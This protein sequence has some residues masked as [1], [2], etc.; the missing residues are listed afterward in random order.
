MKFMFA[1]WWFLLALLLLPA[2]AFLRGKRGA[3]PAFVYSSVTLLANVSKASRSRAGALLHALR[4]LALALLI[5]ALARP[6]KT[7]TE[8]SVR[9]SG[10]D[11]VIA[12]DLS[13][14]MESEDFQIK[15]Q[16]VN[17]LVVAKDTIKQ[18]ILKRPNDRIGLVAF[19]GRAYIA[20][21]LTL[22]HDF[23]QNNLDRLELHTI[24]DGTAIGSGLSAAVNRL[25]DVKSKSKIVVLMTDGQN[26]AGK[27]PPLTAAEAAKALDVKVYTI[28]VGIRGKAPFP[29]N[30]PFGKRYVMMDVDI[31][32]PTLTSIA[33]KTGGK[34]Y[35]ADST[36]TLRKVYDE[37]DRFEKTEA[38]LKK[39]VRR[40]ELFHWAAVPGLLLLLIEVLLASTIW[41]RL[42]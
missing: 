33:D 15:G 24:E 25:R 14:S 16:R 27:I 42:P 2:L 13:G 11:I 28:G 20:A 4:W 7:Q 21:P 26:N 9:A 32:E 10:V 31:D 3:R 29:Q 1:N 5:V 34:Y 35:R 6:Q 40:D 8:T 30:T 12:L 36:D 38:V 41:R 17:R 22:D 39:F 18:F 37:I 19:A 23:L